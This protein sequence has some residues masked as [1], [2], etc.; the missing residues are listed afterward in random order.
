MHQIGAAV[1]TDAPSEL[2]HA[3][4][5]HTCAVYVHTPTQRFVHQVGA[6]VY[7]ETPYESTHRMCVHPDVVSVYTPR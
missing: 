5:V 4:F 6:G 7:T 3:M 1:Y 2:T